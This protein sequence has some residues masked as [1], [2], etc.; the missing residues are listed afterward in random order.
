MSQQV[1]SLFNER[2]IHKVT[3]AFTNKQNGNTSEQFLCSLSPVYI[4][5]QNV[6]G[7]V[8]ISHSGRAAAKL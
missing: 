7:Y 1:G 2:H 4:G 6:L 8:L 5:L 3:V